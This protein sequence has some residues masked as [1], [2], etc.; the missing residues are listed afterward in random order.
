VNKSGEEKWK[1]IIKDYDNTWIKNC[2]DII[3]PYL[4]R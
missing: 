2:S 4:E 3:S 1:K